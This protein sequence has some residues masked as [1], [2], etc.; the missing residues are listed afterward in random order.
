[1][2]TLNKLQIPPLTYRGHCIGG[3]PKMIETNSHVLH[4]K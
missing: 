4:A 3:T 1:M 2:V